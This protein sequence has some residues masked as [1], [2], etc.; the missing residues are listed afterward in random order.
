MMKEYMWRDG[1]SGDRDKVNDGGWMQDEARKT[2]SRISSVGQTAQQ[3]GEL[4]LIELRTLCETGKF[5]LR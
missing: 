5:E 1:C 3:S 4:A 2:A